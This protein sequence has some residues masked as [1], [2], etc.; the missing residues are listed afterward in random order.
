MVPGGQ[1]QECQPLGEATDRHIWLTGF[2]YF[3]IF[4]STYFAKSS[5]SVAKDS[6]IKYQ[7]EYYSITASVLQVTQSYIHIL[8]LFT[9]VRT[10]HLGKYES[11][12][13]RPKS[14]REYKHFYK[15]LENASTPIHRFSQS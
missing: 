5:K 6:E 8:Y 11:N 15:Q 10:W 13:Y 3:F 9:D 2:L 4:S 12:S 1:P 14:D 7:R